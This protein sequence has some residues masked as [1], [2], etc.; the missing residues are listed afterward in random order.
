MSDGGS[1]TPAPMAMVGGLLLLSEPITGQVLVASVLI[2]GGV[3]LGV[4]GRAGPT[5]DAGRP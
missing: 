2:L 5:R 1:G 4:T 3:A